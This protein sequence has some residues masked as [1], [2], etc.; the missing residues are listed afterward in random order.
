M[1]ENAGKEGL[2]DNR[3]LKLYIVGER[4]GNPA[5]WSIECYRAYVIARSPE[6][7]LAVA[8][9]GDD[10]PVAEIIPEEP[11]VLVVEKDD[12]IE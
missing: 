12:G 9:M 11:M 10:E 8:G 1:S 3:P 7:A 2:A 5:D 4:S 6:E